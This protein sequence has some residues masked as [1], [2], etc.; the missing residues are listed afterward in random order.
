ME[1]IENIQNR[2]FHEIFEYTTPTLT[3]SFQLGNELQDRIPFNQVGVLEEIL[4]AEKSNQIEY[5]DYLELLP[6]LN[7]NVGDTQTKFI[8]NTLIKNKNYKELIELLKR[9]K[10]F[11]NMS[12]VNLYSYARSICGK[13]ISNKEYQKINADTNILKKN[14]E[15]YEINK[16][17]FKNQRSEIK[18]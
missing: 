16:P 6:K 11:D 8:S 4:E 10:P 1:S 15:N 3:K 13:P 9:T 18:F 14:T 7:L 12:M 17:H 5:E 2:N